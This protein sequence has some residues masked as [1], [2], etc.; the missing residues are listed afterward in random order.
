[1]KTVLPDICENSG[2]ALLTVSVKSFK[3]LFILLVP[4]HALFNCAQYLLENIFP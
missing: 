3:T 2:C 1:M 4:G